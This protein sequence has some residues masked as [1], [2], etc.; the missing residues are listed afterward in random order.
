MTYIHRPIIIRLTKCKDTAFGE[1][2]NDGV[3][4]FFNAKALVISPIFD[5]GPMFHFLLLLSAKSKSSNNYL[6]IRKQKKV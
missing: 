6:K 4:T 5:N 2:A 1:N 3:F